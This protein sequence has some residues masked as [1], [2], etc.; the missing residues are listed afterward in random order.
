MIGYRIDADF[1]GNSRTLIVAG[2]GFREGKLYADGGGIPTI[3][4]GPGSDLK[5]QPKG[6][7]SFDFL[8]I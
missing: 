8:S 2:E 7:E 5:R 6:S 4:Y 3:G 1:Y